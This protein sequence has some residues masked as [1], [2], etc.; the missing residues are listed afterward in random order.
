MHVLDLALLASVN[1]LARHWWVLD[2]AMSILST[3]HL[4][5]GGVLMALVWAVWFRADGD[6][7]RRRRVILATFGACVAAMAAARSLAL[8]APFRQRPLHEPGLGFVLPIGEPPANM[9]GWSSF[10]SDH[11]TLFFALAMGLFFASRRVGGVALLWTTLAIALPR[12]Y[13]GLHYPSDLL[14]GALIGAGMAAAAARWL[15]PSALIGRV[16]AWA[17]ARPERFYPLFFLYTFQVGEMFDSTRALIGATH[18]FLHQVM[19]R[20]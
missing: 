6:E 19:A 20:V 17:Q 2:K 18:S 15:A 7:T 1:Q 13:L 5:K 14:V 11:A 4:F 9:D 8:L 3:N 16:L 10:P 12:L